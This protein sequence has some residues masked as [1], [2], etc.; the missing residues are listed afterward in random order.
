MVAKFKLGPGKTLVFENI[1]I[2]QPTNMEV[3]E[4]NTNFQVD[5]DLVLCQ[6]PAANASFSNV[7]R[8]PKIEWLLIYNDSP[9][10]PITWPG[11]LISN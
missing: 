9:F 8:G 10:R 3:K 4:K 11:N 2:G 1:R 7:G 5:L 6:W